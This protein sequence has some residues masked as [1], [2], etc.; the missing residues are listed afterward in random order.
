MNDLE[1]LATE[2]SRYKLEAYVFVINAVE[3]TMRSLRRRGHVSGRELLEGIKG[4][5]RREFGPMAK[6]VFESWGVTTTADFGEIVFRLV[7]AGIL[8]KTD[9]DSLE[10]FSDVF[11]FND[12]F[13]RQYDWNIKGVL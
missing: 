3:F 10:D 6:S 2:D 12:V 11:D 9:Q 13:E 8:G 7:G 1:T 5:A 4:L